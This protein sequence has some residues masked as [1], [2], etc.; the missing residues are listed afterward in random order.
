MKEIDLLRPNDE[1]KVDI[2]GP[3]GK[4]LYSSTTNGYHSLEMAVN[5]TLANSKIEIN[6]EDCVFEVSNL[7]TGVTH[8]Y[9][10]NAHGNLKL[11][12]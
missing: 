6:P 9:R 3:D 4:S 11:I 8:R 7:T 2:W 1:I 5:D 12:V 10:L